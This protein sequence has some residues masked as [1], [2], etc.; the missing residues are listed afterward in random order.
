LHP[1][2]LSRLKWDHF[3]NMKLKANGETKINILFRG[4][5][6]TNSL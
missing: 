5:A 3:W 6:A 2:L 4:Y 1:L